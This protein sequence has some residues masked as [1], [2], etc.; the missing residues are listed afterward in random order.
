MTN[1]S[2]GIAACFINPGGFQAG[3]YD[4]LQARM[5]NLPAFPHI[6]GSSNSARRPPI[7]AAVSVRLP[8]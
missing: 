3:Y 7:G 5:Q 2:L 8:P 6:P 4:L 1:I